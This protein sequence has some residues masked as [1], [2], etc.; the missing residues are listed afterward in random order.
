MR[1]FLGSDVY[2]K[3]REI[4]KVMGENTRPIWGFDR[5]NISTPELATEVE[6][7]LYGK[8]PVFIC[9][10]EDRIGF[11]AMK[12]FLRKFHKEPQKSAAAFINVLSSLEGTDVGGWFENKLRTQ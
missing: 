1:E 8:G 3:Y 12:S 2:A 4:R 6:A 5:S 9:E 11:E 10:L 7:I